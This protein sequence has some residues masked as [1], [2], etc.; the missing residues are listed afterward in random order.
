[1]ATIE[2][3]KFDTITPSVNAEGGL[4]NLFTGQGGQQ[5]FVPKTN[6]NAGIISPE[7]IT[8]T[9]PVRLPETSVSPAIPPAI[10]PQD[11]T[12][13]P[14]IPT[15]ETITPLETERTGLMG[16]FK[17]LQEK[18]TGKPTAQ[19]EA[20]AAQGIPEKA[21]AVTDIQAQINQLE[22]ESTIAKIR[23][24]QSGETTQFGNA[25]IAQI[26]RDRTIKAL[27]LNSFLYAAQG[28]LATAQD[29]VDRAVSAQFAPIEAE[30]DY[31][32]KFLDLNRDDL[33]R[34]DKKKADALQIQLDERKRLLDEQKAERTAIN[35]IAIEA[36]QAGADAVLLNK[37]SKATTQQEALQ[38]M[39]SDPKMF[40]WAAEQARKSAELDVQLKQAQIDKL[41]DGDGGIPGENQQLYA[42]LK[43][44]TATAVRGQVSA[45]KTEPTVQ[46]F[47]VV[48]EGRNFAQSLAD[49]T[50]NPADDQGLIYSLAKALD[51]GSVVREGEYAT[52]QKYA[53]SWVKAYGKGV[54][55][56]IA[57]TGFLSVEARKNIKKTIE[58]KYNASKKSYDNMYGQYTKGINNLTG[59]DDGT[60]FLR[61]YAIPEEEQPEQQDFT[62]LS[63]EDFLMSVP[64]NE[65]VD[66]QSYFGGIWNWITGK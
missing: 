9:Q 48:Q 64:I 24:Q 15:A 18:I 29:M 49:T 4:G 31:I 44:P 58:S 19:A 51:P 27:Q 14:E 21:Q 55:Q 53:Q 59:R 17:D 56:A 43:A 22:N 1:M 6:Q 52:A 25:Q 23:A 16:R 42:G 63:N 11:T 60:A 26:E 57:G 33:S 28:N 5:M 3:P 54:E 7:S 41:R 34:E 40:Q 2:K 39:A 30:I 65:E 38:I 10:A 12:T 62:S 66:N 47:A 13:I 45:F 8:P 35:N 46:N 37:I 20:E 61:D 50:K 32:E 36:A